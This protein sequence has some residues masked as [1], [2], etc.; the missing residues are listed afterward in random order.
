VDMIL[1]HPP[2]FRKNV[3]PYIP[4]ECYPSILIWFP[5]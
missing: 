2:F 5:K 3:F 1:N 4:S